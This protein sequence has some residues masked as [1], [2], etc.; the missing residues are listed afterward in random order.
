LSGSS[1]VNGE[2]KLTLEPDAKP[3][4]VLRSLVEQGVDLESFSHSVMPLEDIFIKVVREGLGLDHGQSGPPTA[5][6]LSLAG[7]GSQGAGR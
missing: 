3:R 5:D 4:D 6:D 7:A 1:P 2:L